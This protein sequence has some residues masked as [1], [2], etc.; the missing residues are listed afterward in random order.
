P[1]PA[2]GATCNAAG[3]LDPVLGVA[4]PQKSGYNF[5]YTS[6]AAVPPI[7]APATCAAAGGAGFVIAGRPMKVGTTGQRTFCSDESGSIFF[8][9]AGGAAPATEAAC[10][11]LTALGTGQ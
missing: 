9:P 2:A 10:E 7:V 8:D 4:A 5:T 3:L 11:A 6:I 1:A